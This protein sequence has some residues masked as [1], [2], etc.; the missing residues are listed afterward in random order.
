MNKS[1]VLIRESLLKDLHRK[2]KD[3]VPVLHL[4]RVYD[5]P[6]SAPTLTKLIGFYNLMLDSKGEVHNTIHKSL[7]PPWLIEDMQYHNTK[8]W[9]Y[10]GKMPIGEWEQLK[11]V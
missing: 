7:F 3:G 2:N 6:L 5:L 11:R 4:L 1:M 10:L 9:I 8:T